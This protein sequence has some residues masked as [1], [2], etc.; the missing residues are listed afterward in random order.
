[1]DEHSDTDF[2]KLANQVAKGF[3]KNTEEHQELMEVQRVHE[4][5]FDQVAASGSPH[6]AK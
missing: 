3:E 4:S 2:L 5:R 6:R 1:M